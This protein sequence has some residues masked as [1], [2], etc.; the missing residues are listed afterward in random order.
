MYPSRAPVGLINATGQCCY[1]NAACQ[2]IFHCT[3]LRNCIIRSTAE[4]STGEEIDDVAHTLARLFT[5]LKGGETQCSVLPVLL[6]LQTGRGRL[7]GIDLVMDPNDATE[8][9]VLLLD[10][11]TDGLSTVVSRSA[12]TSSR[13]AYTR[14]IDVRR[15]MDDAWHLN[16]AGDARS[17]CWRRGM[18]TLAGQLVHRVACPK[19]REPKWT[20][21][22]T[23][24][25][26]ILA[27]PICHALHVV[28]L[29]DCLDATM[30][31]EDE[32]CG[33]YTCD[34]CA[35]VST[36]GVT[37][38]TCWWR[39]P[40]VLLLALN[41]FGP[42]CERPVILPLVLSMRRWAHPDSPCAS[43]C[44]DLVGTIEHQGR[45]SR[46]GHYVAGVRMPDNE[47]WMLDDNSV[48]RT[49]GPDGRHIY[50]VAYTFIKTPL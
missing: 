28:K 49:G 41:R 45:G 33:P 9:I 20:A 39:A 22:P 24:G 5:A 35:C 44:Y 46:S 15:I 43:A 37:K 50:V 10:A 18:A 21:E 27:P 23:W 11:L 8:F 38:S 4:I 14:T 29:D 36:S 12:Y 26:I 16:L 3:A 32:V 42:Q 17:R 34:R 13:S 6:A 48:R 7:A 25:A 30:C 1:A 2:L 47:W 40:P 31:T 19:C